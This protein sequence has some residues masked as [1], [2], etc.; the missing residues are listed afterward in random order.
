M[1]ELL[2]ICFNK[3][4]EEKL[5]VYEN[6]GFC[7]IYIKDLDKECFEKIFEEN[8]KILIISTTEDVR[9]SKE[10]YNKIKILKECLTL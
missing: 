7:R 3:T 4:A 10:L 8:D 2:G 6:E 5:K 9:N 1:C